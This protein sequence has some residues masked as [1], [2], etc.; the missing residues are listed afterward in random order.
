MNEVTSPIDEVRIV[1]L[2]PDWTTAVALYCEV[3]QNPDAN[4]ISKRD[5]VDDLMRLA[6]H[7]DANQ[8]AMLTGNDPYDG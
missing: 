6:R 8:S 1:N 3:L 7:V 5:A 4:R 2:A